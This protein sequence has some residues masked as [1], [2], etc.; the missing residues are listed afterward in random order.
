MK[1]PAPQSEEI[2]PWKVCRPF[3]QQCTSNHDDNEYNRLEG[4]RYESFYLR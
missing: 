3:S 4:G 2:V 1:R